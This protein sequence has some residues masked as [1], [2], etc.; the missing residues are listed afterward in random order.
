MQ[1]FLACLAN[2]LLWFTTLFYRGKD[3]Q[4]IIIICLCRHWRNVVEQL[5]TRF[6]FFNVRGQ[7]RLITPASIRLAVNTNY[8]SFFILKMRAVSRAFFPEYKEFFFFSEL[9]SWQVTCGLW[10]RFEKRNSAPPHFS[11]LE[12]FTERNP[13]ASLSES[14]R[15]SRSSL[16]QV[17]QWLWCDELWREDSH[18]H[19]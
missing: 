17:C 12:M 10:F 15:L 18:N 2:S 9:K 3:V 11:L 7:V 14:R 19:F 1:R 4:R 5:F 13:S 16:Q 8:T 6:V